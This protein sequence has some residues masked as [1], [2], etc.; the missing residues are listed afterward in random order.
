[1]KITQTKLVDFGKR[2]EL[3]VYPVSIGA[4]RLPQDDSEAVSLLR[5]AIDAG[6]IYIDTSRGYGDSE[7]KLAKALKDGYREKVILS[8]KWCPWN[9]KIE[10]TD[11]TSA[12][13]VYK[14]LLESMK[15][16]D[17]DYLDFYQ[18]WSINN[19]EQ[20]LGAT[21]KGGMLD[22]IFRA[23]KEGLVKHIGFTTHDKPEN[24]S[25]YIDEADWCESILFTYNILD[26]SYEEAIAKA[27]EKGIATIVMNPIGG[28]VLTEDS[29]PLND[30][31]KNAIGAADLIEIAHRWLKSNKNIDTIICGI[32]KPSDITST[33]ENYEKDPLTAEQK[34]RLSAEI[35][36][37]SKKNVGFC[38]D[39]K[40]CLPCPK[41]IDIPGFMHIAYFSEFLKA[42]ERARDVYNWLVNPSNASKSADPG[43]CIECGKCEP[44]CTQKIEIVEMLKTLKSKFGQ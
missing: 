34:Q 24:V 42:D 5:Q 15:R 2:S 11:D 25:R 3:K 17:A 31:V 39:C 44:K 1:M 26:T 10:P 23:K 21:C 41:G 9:I 35:A 14:R 28:G 38:V 40:Y 20:W 12:E 43:E 32:T 8:T 19:N 16:L 18:L 33:I 4:M 6:M 29:P 36:K 37:I 27:H 7:L 13:C 30:A 22:G